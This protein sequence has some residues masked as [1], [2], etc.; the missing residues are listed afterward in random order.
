MDYKEIDKVLHD[1]I[2]VFIE[3]HKKDIIHEIRIAVNK[4]VIAYT[5][6]GEKIGKEIVT[7]DEL[8]IIVR[9]ISKFSIYAFEDEIRQGFLT[10]KE[11]HRVGI[12]GECVIENGEIKI[13]KNIAS[14]NI[15]M[16]R[17]IYGCSNSVIEYILR[18]QGIYNTIIISPPKCGKTTM[19]RDITRQLSDGIADNNVSGRRVCVIDERSE[20]AACKLGVPEM[21]VGLRTDVLDGCPKAI[22][23]MMA[24]RT[25][26]PDIIVCDE[27]G[28][29]KDLNSIISACTCGVN[30]I[31][32][33][34]GQSI[35]DLY[36]KGISRDIERNKVFQRAII[37]S[38]DKGPGHIKA[39]YDLND[40]VNLW[41]AYDD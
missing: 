19:L 5:T 36:S 4:P 13:I 29:E 25:L 33:I 18:D 27:I 31:S 23:I 2:K 32:T 30:I 8:E 6:T 41:G 14:L 1:H 7:K 35:E 10:L 37:L 3:K 20:I 11:G 21:D 9:K 40:N 17:E 24:I 28:T 38:N 16:A 34:H 22:G 15:R 12:C 39:I 26:A